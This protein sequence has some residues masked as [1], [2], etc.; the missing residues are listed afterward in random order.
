MSTIMA[1][2]WRGAVP[3]PAVSPGPLQPSHRGTLG[4]VASSHQK[5]RYAPIRDKRA[6][7]RAY[8]LA[9]RRT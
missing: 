8:R 5:S 9:G 4:C 3:S 7:G 2:P 6:S 1:A